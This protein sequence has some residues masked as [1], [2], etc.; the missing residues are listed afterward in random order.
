MRSSYIDSNTRHTLSF[1]SQEAENVPFATLLYS[2]AY[3][4]GIHIRRDVQG[5]TTKREYN[6]RVSTRLISF[7]EMAPL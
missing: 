2:L 3:H 1:V 7:M 4:T 6:R 5:S